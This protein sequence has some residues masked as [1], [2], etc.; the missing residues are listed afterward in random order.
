M[1]AKL[2]GYVTALVMVVVILSCLTTLVSFFPDRLIVEN[3]LVNVTETASCQF[4]PR[5][6]N[7][8]QAISGAFVGVLSG[9]GFLEENIY[10]DFKKDC[11]DPTDEVTFFKV[12][13]VLFSGITG[14]LAGANMSGEL[15]NPGKAIPRG[16]LAA[17]AFTFGWFAL[18]LSLTAETCERTLIYNDC[19]YLEKI[20][21]WPPSVTIGAFFITFSATFSHLIGASRV[22][23]AVAKDVLFGP[24]LNFVIVGRFGDNP[25]AAVLLTWMFVQAFFFAGGLNA[26]AQLV[27]VLFLLSY[28]AVNLSCLGLHLASAPNFRP[29]FKF[30]SWHTCL[31]GV[32][33]TTVMMFLIN[34]ILSALSILL[35][36]SLVF[37]LSLFSPAKDANWGSISQAL[38]FHQVRKYLLLMDPRKAHIKFWRP[39]ILLLVKNPR[40]SCTLIDFVNMMKKGGLFVL[41]HIHEE[42]N[43]DDIVISDP[44]LSNYDQWLSYIDHLNVKAFVELTSATN[45][46]EGIRHLVRLS[47]I[48]AM[49]PN[50][51]LL[52]FKDN[53]PSVDELT[54][55]HSSFSTMKFQ[56]LF[57]LSLHHEE[58]KQSA[59][60]YVSVIKDCLTLQKNVGLCR[61]FQSLNRSYLSR[62]NRGAFLN[63]QSKR[64][65][66]LDI[67]LVDFLSPYKVTNITDTTSLFILQLASI[68]GRVPRWSK[69]SLRIFTFQKGIEK[70]DEEQ[71]LKRMLDMLRIKAKTELLPASQTYEEGKQ[72]IQQMNELVMSRSK[73]TAV[74]FLYMPCLP[75]DDSKYPEFLDSLTTLTNY[76]P[77]TI[78]VRGVSPVM[79]TTL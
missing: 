65:K 73:D 59:L 5:P 11:S 42:E 74:V 77:P 43:S 19:L 31:C 12:F 45:L 70:K 76:L 44:C 21:L 16:S 14:I 34:P 2:V 67:W 47:G 23:E 55:A 53:E 32:I 62:G 37:G 72:Y 64:K 46:R 68:V 51:I 24:F 25:V 60:E 71:K 1:G 78:I 20:S 13:G 36:V 54:A 3:F 57:P 48:G 22:L 27:S 35:C 18:L 40:T 17:L 41:G 69:L 10:M 30:F 9:D 29:S 79:T 6:L 15:K 52:G 39:Q 26:I 38:M 28:A 4:E 66:Y 58:S 75:H 56:R 50:T 61:N 49:K 63:F 7:C 8:T 33:G